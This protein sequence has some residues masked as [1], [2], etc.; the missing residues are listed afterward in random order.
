MI[1]HN[2]ISYIGKRLHIHV[3]NFH[4]NNSDSCGDR[5]GH[6]GALLYRNEFETTEDVT[7]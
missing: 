2:L 6:I 1:G 7:S 3:E 5:Q 4:F